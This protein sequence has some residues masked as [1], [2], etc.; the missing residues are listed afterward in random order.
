MIMDNRNVQM[1]TDEL[2]TL[3]N[4]DRQSASPRSCKEW[5]ASHPQ[6][7]AEI[8]DWHTTT[9]IL[10]LA[11]EP[12]ITEQMNRQTVG[13]G[14]NVLAEM[15]AKYAVS[16]TPA[17]VSLAAAAQSRGMTLGK[18][19]ASLGLSHALMSKLNNRLLRFESL[20]SRLVARLAEILEVTVGQVQ[21]YLQQ[22][23]TLAQGAAYKS[24]GVPTV[25]EQTDFADAINADLSMTP[26]QKADWLRQE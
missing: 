2:Y 26:E 6:H 1:N 19:A 8:M 13:I 22:P 21:R 24:D 17:L 23:A 14:M 16:Q 9:T 18:V 15:R 11:P 7:A 20:P 12:T 3:W 10:E 25:A 5:M 4:D